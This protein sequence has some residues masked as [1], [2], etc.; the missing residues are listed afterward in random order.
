[1][2]TKPMALGV[3]VLGPLESVLAPLEPVLA[4][5]ELVFAPLEPVGWG[6]GGDG[7]NGGIVV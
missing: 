6:M 5:W 2:A 7:G 4:A 1:M 3:L